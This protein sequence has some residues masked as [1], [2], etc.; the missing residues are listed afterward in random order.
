M[1]APVGVP[2]LVDAMLLSLKVAAVA[3]T[4]ATLF[5]FVIVWEESDFD[6]ATDTK[7]T[8][9]MAVEIP[10]TGEA[11]SEPGRPGGLSGLRGRRG[12]LAGR[13]TVIRRT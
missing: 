4:V 8:R 3:T 10:M 5:G 13:G 1:A 12:R 6:Q 2:Q 11:G 7:N 9:I